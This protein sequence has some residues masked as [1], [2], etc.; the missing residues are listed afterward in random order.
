[1]IPL[2]DLWKRIKFG[3][4][5]RLL[6]LVSTGIA[7][8]VRI[9]TVGF[10]HLEDMI[11]SGEGGVV[12]IW[13]GVTMLPIFYCR[14]RGLWAIISTSRDGEL[15]NRMVQSRGFKTIRGSSG[16]HGV[17]A[18]L[19]AVKR[20]KEGAIFAI[21]PDGPKGPNKVV[22]HGSV[23]LAERA[24]CPVISVGI[25][26]DRAKRLHSWDKHMIPMPFSRAVIVFRDPITI[27][28]SDTDEDRQKWADILAD[29]LNN[30][31]A[32]A[33]RLLKGKV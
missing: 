30:A 17:R 7:F 14:H 18:F 23:L 27:G 19:G 20:V 10:E 2:K 28:A 16:A 26:C 5:W 8:T 25:A 3:L 13:H 29:E 9:R 15:Q 33:E 22:Q 21:T 31:E 1:M 24:G 4:T 12:V 6:W 32:E 11:A